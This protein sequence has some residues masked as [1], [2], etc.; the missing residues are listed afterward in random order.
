MG[1]NVKVEGGHVVVTLGCSCED[2]DSNQWLPI[3]CKLCININDVY[4]DKSEFLKKNVHVEMAF[5]LT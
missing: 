2:V 1:K 3:Q 4:F 5:V